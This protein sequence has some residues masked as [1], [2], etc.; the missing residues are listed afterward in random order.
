MFNVRQI[1]LSLWILVL[2]VL[3]QRT[4][5]VVVDVVVAASAEAES[6][7]ERI[8]PKITKKFYDLVATNG[9]SAELKFKFIGSPMPH[10][11]WYIKNKEVLPPRE[12]DVKV[13]GDQC[14]FTLKEVSMEDAGKII[15]KLTNPLGED[16]CSAQLTVIEDFSKPKSLPKV[17]PKFITR[18]TDVDVNQGFEARFKSKVIGEPIPTVTWLRNGVPLKVSSRL[19]GERFI[20]LRCCHSLE[21]FKL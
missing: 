8:A 7:V 6:D 4:Y 16:R 17:A 14:T 21:P 20:W 12:F 19:D 1:L 9:H 13:E 11:Q 5:F 15:V 2:N 3:L 10:I 18:F